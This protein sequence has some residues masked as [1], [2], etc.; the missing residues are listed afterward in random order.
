MNELNIFENPE[1]GSIRTMVIDDEP[2]FVGKD[3]A[4][5]LGYKNSS[6]AIVKHIDCED[7]GVANCDS[8]GGTQ[9]MT[10]INE[11]GLYSLIL[12]SK[13]PSAKKFK[14]WVTSEVLPAIRKTGVYAIPQR[15]QRDLTTDDYLKAAQIVAHCR[16]ERLP[17]V[18]HYLENAG[19]TVPDVK[20]HMKLCS[21]I[22]KKSIASF[23][24]CCEDIENRATNLVYSQYQKYCIENNLDALSHGEFSKQIKQHL[25]LSIIDKRL[26]G[27]KHRIFV[28]N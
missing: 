7:K 25:G 22:V 11:S 8:P 17:Y 13:L 2:W 4:S 20:S 15:R 14:R 19:F 12:S 1:F 28:K 21:N 9:S 18:F 27:K 5:S 3:I 6:D 16:N 23:I 24:E 10:I 26:E